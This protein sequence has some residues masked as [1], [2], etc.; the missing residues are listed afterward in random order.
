MANHV[1]LDTL[2][3]R[4]G[5]LFMTDADSAVPKDWVARHVALL[6]GGYDAVAGLINLHPGDCSEILPALLDRGAL[7]NRYSGLLDRLECLLDPVAHD[8]WPRH[9]NASGANM[10]VRADALRG[11][12]DFP[13][14]A[15]GEDRLFIRMLEAQGRKVRHDCENR[16]FTSG[17]LFGRAAG[18]MADTLRH[19]LRV[20]DAVCDPRL[21]F[22]DRAYYRASLRKRLRSAWPERDSFPSAAK[23]WADHF[24]V[25]DQ[26]AVNAGACKTF[27]DA[28]QKLETVSPLLKRRPVSPC[29]LPAEIA[30]AESLV[31]RLTLGSLVNTH[32]EPQAMFA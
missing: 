2:P 17:R 16:V 6:R 21:E 27:E 26:L 5:L 1:A 29:H 9:Y 25:S 11:M 15:C 18:G 14:I 23:V 4:G 13:Q 22:A 24:P 8:P 20:P 30:R 31:Q 28:W 32:A 12:D 3:D 7:E 10:A 19:Q